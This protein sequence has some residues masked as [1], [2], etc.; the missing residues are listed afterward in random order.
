MHTYADLD[1]IVS[2]I[3][4]RTD[5]KKTFIYADNIATGVEIINHLIGLLP[6]ELRDT[7]QGYDVLRPYNAAL[8]KEY[9]KKAMSM[10]KEGQVR[11]L[12]IAVLLVEPSAYSIDLLEGASK[13]ASG[14]GKKKGVDAEKESDAMKRLKSKKRKEHARVRGVHRGSAG[15][16]N[17]VI[18]VADTPSLDPEADEEGLLVFVQTG[19]CRHAVL[20]L[21]YKNKPLQPV[22]PCCEICCPALLDQ[23]RPGT[24]PVV[25][26]Q[27]AVKRGEINKDVQLALHKWRVGIKARDYPTPLFGA[28]GI[29]QD[30]TIAL[31]S[32]VGPFS[33]RERLVKVLS[34]QWTWWDKYGDELYACL[35]ALTIP[36]MVPLPSKRG[37]KRGPERG[38]EA[39]GAAVTSKRPNITEPQITAVTSTAESTPHSTSQGTS[40]A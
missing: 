13:T 23:T 12:G 29:L 39:D 30:E 4:S 28:S 15:G 5:I 27:S 36:P 7:V 8:S 10:F 19:E 9:R 22:V 18:F 33:S 17:D 25:P 40:T 38:S 2:G 32:S 3:K 1:F 31:L 21:I 20:T 24:P 14:R 26:R 34:G 6:P 37:K 16:E 35:A 11:I